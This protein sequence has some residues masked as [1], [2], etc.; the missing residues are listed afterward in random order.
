MNPIEMNP[1]N[2]KML[3]PAEMA[4]ALKKECGKPDTAFR[5][6]F[7][8]RP[9]GDAIGSAYALALCLY[10][11]GADTETVC[12]DPVPQ[13]FHELTKPAEEI[14]SLPHGK[15]EHVVNIAVDTGSAS[16][17]GKYSDV[18]IDICIDHHVTNYINNPEHLPAALRLVEPEESSCAE[19]IF[20]LFGLMNVKMSVLEADLIYTGLITDAS[21]FRARCTRRES[22]ITAAAVSE[23]NE[24]HIVDI[25]RKHFMRKRPAQIKM[26]T[27]AYSRMRFSEDES[28]LGTYVTYNDY[29][30]CGIED[31]DLEGFNDAIDQI[32]RPDGKG[33][34]V[35]VIVREL[36][37]SF[38]RVSVTAR[39]PVNA[40]RICRGLG[41][42][43]HDN[44]AGCEM[45][46]DPK[47]ALDRTMEACIEDIKNYMPG[48][49]LCHMDTGSS[50]RK[51]K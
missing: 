46:C 37:P 21:C 30:E 16:R 9:D 40:A 33:V 19:I 3:T 23:I 25:A 28:V 11:L 36:K 17:L 51:V 47:E 24:E 14:L 4:E 2:E 43:G 7:H 22:L 34:P 49:D 48:S 31:C 44:A 10:S 27:A 5:I 20:K 18:K 8:K 12:S 32:C 41:G 15:K 1:N 13:R 26:E 39:L 6:F 50:L 38:C 45:N 42:G 29:R 35:H